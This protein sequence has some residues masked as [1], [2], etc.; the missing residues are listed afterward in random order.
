MLF[1]PTD[2]FQIKELLCVTRH[3]LLEFA[4]QRGGGVGDLMAGKQERAEILVHSLSLSPKS[5]S[6]SGSCA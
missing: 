2:G 6:S 4:F 5:R 3:L 1:L